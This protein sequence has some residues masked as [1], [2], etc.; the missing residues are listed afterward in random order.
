MT[1]RST[2]HGSKSATFFIDIAGYSKLATEEESDAVPT[3]QMIHNA[4]RI[5]DIVGVA[6]EQNEDCCARVVGVR[7]L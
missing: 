4:V 1:R 6:R 5:R 3:P 2:S 7:Q